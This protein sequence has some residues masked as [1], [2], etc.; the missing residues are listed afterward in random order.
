[1]M[2]A[3]GGSSESPIRPV[4]RTFYDHMQVFLEHTFVFVH[5][6]LVGSNERDK[7]ESLSLELYSQDLDLGTS[8][9]RT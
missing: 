9:S 3:D 7:M 4:I 5:F 6:Q 2:V 8:Y 1:M